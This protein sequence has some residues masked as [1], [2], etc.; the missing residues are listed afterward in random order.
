MAN[1][2]HAH[3]TALVLKVL[4]GGE[5][6][7]AQL[8][9]ATQSRLFKFCLLLCRNREVAEDLCQETL[10]KALQ[11][12]KSLK[13]PNTFLGWIYRIAR[14]LYTDI[15]RKPGSRDETLDDVAAQAANGADLDVV[16]NVQ[17]ILAKFEPDE[18]LLLLLVELEGCSY[19]EAGEVLELSE[20]AVRS[21]LHRLRGAFI[22]KYN[23]SEE[24]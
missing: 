14:N 3:F 20:D 9:E 5:G 18:R 23:S 15:K 1:Q 6:A 21:K 16:M 7:S 2:D 11:N 10:L 8:I 12:I 24:S 22:R 13:D 4:E 19:K 17:K